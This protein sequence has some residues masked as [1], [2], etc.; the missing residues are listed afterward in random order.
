M[1]AVG[2]PVGL[3]GG[4][5]LAGAAVRL[6]ATGPDGRPVVPPLQLVLLDGSTLVVVLAAVVAGAGAVLLAAASTLRGPRPTAP[7]WTCGEAGP[8]SRSRTSSSPTRGRP[9]R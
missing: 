1:L 8:S 3:L 9:D 2:D 5:G 4:V 6:L 7:S